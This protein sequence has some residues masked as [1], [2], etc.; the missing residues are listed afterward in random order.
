MKDPWYWNNRD[1]IRAREAA[2][3]SANPEPAKARARKYQAENRE[4][5]LRKKAEYRTSRRAQLAAQENAR[6]H[7]NSETIKQKQAIRRALKRDET[8]RKCRERSAA[9]TDNYARELLAKS[10]P[11]SMADFPQAL[12]DAKR[13]HIRLKRITKSK[14]QQKVTQ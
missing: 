10:S 14:R 11:I 1:K 9:I 4:T 13:L 2:R 12:V 6:Y 5:V 8:R 7:A 3:Y